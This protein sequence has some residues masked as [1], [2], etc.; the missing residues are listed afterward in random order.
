MDDLAALYRF[1]AQG[2]LRPP[3]DDFLAAASAVPELEPHL[4]TNLSDAYTWLFEFNVYPYASVYLDPSGM[5]NAPWSGFVAGVYRALGL[6]VAA[7]AGLAA[8]DHLSAGLGAVASLLEREAAATDELTRTRA[9]HAQRTL[10]VEQLLPWLPTFSAAVRELDAGFYG[11]LT[12]MTL[13]LSL[14]HAAELQAETARPFTYPKEETEVGAGAKE[15]LTRFMTPARS[16]MFLSRETVVRLGRRLGVPVRFAERA[17]MLEQL[18]LAAADA[19]KLD[20]FF[21]E[22]KREAEEQTAALN[23]LQKTWPS[24]APLWTA[25]VDKLERAAAELQQLSEDVTPVG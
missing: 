3:N 1:L 9:R 8:S 5:L 17:Y 14:E 25:A 2:Y 24:L 4:K 23:S 6:E 7:D 22:L 16:G 12:E 21:L 10:L 19:E 18:A 13:S 20:R 11:V 15:Q